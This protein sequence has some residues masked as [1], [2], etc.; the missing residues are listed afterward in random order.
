MGMYECYH[1]IIHYYHPMY[2]NLWQWQYSEM[3][4]ICSLSYKMKGQ[5]YDYETSTIYEQ[6]VKY[7]RFIN[8]TLFIC[9]DVK[10]WMSVCGIL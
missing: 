9:V 8:V 3:V 7:E 4:D 6:K 5:W 10:E 1:Q 2:N